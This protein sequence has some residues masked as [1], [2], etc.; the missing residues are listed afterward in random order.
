MNKRSAIVIGL[1]FFGLLGAV[2]AGEFPEIKSLM[3]EQEFNATGVYKLS[4]EELEALSNWLLKYTRDDV[5]V[6]VKE[7]PELKQAVALKRAVAVEPETNEP[8]VSRISGE[9]SGWSGKTIF[10]L[11]NGQTWKQRL[12]GRYHHTMTSPEVEISKNFLGYHVM[13]V[14]ET[15]RRIGVKR[16]R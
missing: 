2:S 16:L 1:L 3:T 12:S 13:K 9:F 15:G 4:A 5:P 11:E 7:V 10:K 14:T 8:I 6:L